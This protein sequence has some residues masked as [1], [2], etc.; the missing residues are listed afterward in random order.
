[1]FYPENILRT[2]VEMRWRD[3]P[4]SEYRPQVV[5]CPDRLKCP[6]P[7]MDLYSGRYFIADLLLA[8]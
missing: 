8:P 1:M 4:G 2:A 3:P 5:N 6:I 7:L